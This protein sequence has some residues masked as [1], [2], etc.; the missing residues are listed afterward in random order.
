MQTI[1]ATA[2]SNGCFQV[3]A[4]DARFQPGINKALRFGFQYHPGF[5]LAE[6]GRIQ[7]GGLGVVGMNLYR[8]SFRGVEK[9]YYQWESRLWIML[10]QQ[11]AAVLCY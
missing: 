5:R 4:V 7:P 10:S 2:F 8:E 1:L 11:F 9:F 3:L 6:V